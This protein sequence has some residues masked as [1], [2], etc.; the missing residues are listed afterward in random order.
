MK[1]HL[2]VAGASA[3]AL[4]LAWGAPSAALA[5]SNTSDFGL[6]VMLGEPTGLTAKIWSG[7]NKA[8]DFGLAWSTGKNDGMTLQADY[9]R[10]RFDLIDVEQGSLPFYYGIGVRFRDRDNADSN[11]GV[12]FPLGLDYLFADEP[13]D[14]F[15]EVAPILDLTPDSDIDINGTLGVRY[16]F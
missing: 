2:I 3:L 7:P 13:F 14:I 15:L 16:Y 1:N 11:V 10:H 4:L 5:G 12:R 8:F 6:G 9:V